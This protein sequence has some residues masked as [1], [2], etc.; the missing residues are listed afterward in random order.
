MEQGV[1]PAKWGTVVPR[2]WNEERS[3]VCLFY[4]SNAKNGG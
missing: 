4:A 2:R 1:V 3:S